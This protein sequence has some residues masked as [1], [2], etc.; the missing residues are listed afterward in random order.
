MFNSLF[1][2]LGRFKQGTEGERERESESESTL[3]LNS[4]PR[5]YLKAQ[6][7]NRHASLKLKLLYTLFRSSLR[8]NSH[9]GALTSGCGSGIQARCSAW[10]LHG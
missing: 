9:A 1:A 8:H 10:G 4:K 2:I 7:L 6:L 5:K 3:N